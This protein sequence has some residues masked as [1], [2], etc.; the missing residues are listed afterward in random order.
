M[1]PDGR[2][3]LFLRSFPADFAALPQIRSE[4]LDAARQAGWGG[5]NLGRLELVLEEG[6]LNIISHAYPDRT[7][8]IEITLIALGAG[9]LLRLEDGGIPFD[10][11]SAPVPDL[12]T[13]MEERPIGGLGIHLMKSIAEGMEYRRESE[14][15]VLD[16]MLKQQ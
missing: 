14:R 8:E 5:D 15:N 10:P 3:I 4:V 6:A 2:R 12:G 13:A 1:V 11:V 7:G 16:I 9:L